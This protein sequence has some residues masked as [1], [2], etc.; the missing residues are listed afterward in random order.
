MPPSDTRTPGPDQLP[1]GVAAEIGPIAEQIG[2]SPDIVRLLADE[3]WPQAARGCQAR[4][5]F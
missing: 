1:K 5:G 2:L 3:R 4:I